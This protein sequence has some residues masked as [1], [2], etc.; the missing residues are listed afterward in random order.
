MANSGVRPGD[1]DAAARGGVEGLRS[2]CYHGPHDRQYHDPPRV[3]LRA[4]CERYGSAG[5]RPRPLLRHRG[6]RRAD[7]ARRADGRAPDHQRRPL[8]HRLGRPDRLRR[9]GADGPAGLLRRRGPRLRV[10]QGRIRHPGR[11]PGAQARRVR[12]AQDQAAQ[13]RRAAVP[14]HRPGHLPRH[15]PARPQA[16]DRR[17][18]AQRRGDRPGR[19][20]Q[21]RLQGQA[22]LVLRRHRPARLRPGQ[23]RHGRR[24]D[25]PAREA[26][27][28][29]R[30]RPEVLRRPGRL[31]QAHGPDGGRG[32][33]LALRAG[34]PARRVRPRAD[35]R[36]LPP[37]AGAGRRAGGGLRRLQRREGPVREAQGRPGRPG[38]LPHR[39]P[40]PR[41]GRRGPSTSTSPPPTR[42]CG[43]RPT[44]SATWT[45][46]PTRA[47]PA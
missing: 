29:R 43:S 44:G 5:V 33:R 2:R 16:A 28:G 39:L 30:D 46:P 38:P 8:L 25:R 26:R 4:G 35:A 24:H 32:R 15:R 19:H 6:R 41:P 36:L 22:L 45:S 21:R 47:T 12:E 14:D 11:G 3:A 34:R 18:A 17:A 13:H 1:C 7:R 31:R 42:R 23:L 9:A 10:R 40:V 27:P 37:A 20:P